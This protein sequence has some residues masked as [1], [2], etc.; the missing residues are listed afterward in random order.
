MANR[1][2]GRRL[3]LLLW[4][5]SI[6]YLPIQA[7]EYQ[8]ILQTSSAASVSALASKYGF[9]VLKPLYTDQAGNS[10]VLIQTRAL[11]ND[12]QIVAFRAEPGV[13]RLERDSSLNT[14]EVQIQPAASNGLETL[15]EALLQRSPVQ[16]FGSSVRYSYVNQKAT[17][18]IQLQQAQ[19][20]FPTGSAIVAVIDTGADYNHPALKNVLLPGYDFTRDRAD[21]VSE[22]S[23]LD[24]STVA[25]LD[26]ST[27]AI[28]DSK[29]VP[30][31]LSQSTVA[32]L[33]QSTVAILDSK[34][35][36]R[37]FG[38]GTMVAGLVHLVA[39]TARI[40]PI[41]AFHGDGTANLSDVARAIRYAADR[42]ANIITMSFSFPTPSQEIQAAM[43]YA[44][45][46]GVFGIA[47]AGNDGGEFRLFPAGLPSVIGVGSTNFSDKRS[48]FSNFGRAVRTSAPGEALVTTYPGNNY[49]GVW[50]TS[51]STGLAGGTAALILQLRPNPKFDFFLDAFDH[52]RPVSLNMGEA[53]VDLMSIL[54]FVISTP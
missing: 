16:Y 45:A 8:Y 51:F 43:Q 14:G 41:K 30:V 28:L 15:G 32:I 52:G 7:A 6:F 25:I 34:N 46:K 21:T 1:I 26:Q 2:S 22:L 53:R 38:H 11:I 37:A 36:P 23:D 4:L 13:I 3:G 44:A 50:G 17:Q 27:V 42:G 48:P 47:A 19:S 31:V 49:A 9:V 18:L 54:N 33:D 39:P 20:Q 10:A 29:T 12:G 40:L 5:I 35:L 24:Q